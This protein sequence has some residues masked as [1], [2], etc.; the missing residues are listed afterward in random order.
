MGIQLDPGRLRCGLDLEALLLR[1]H[2]DLL[3]LAVDADLERQAIWVARLRLC[4]VDLD[5]LRRGVILPTAFDDGRPGT[6]QPLLEE[7]AQVRAETSSITLRKSA[8]EAL[9]SRYRR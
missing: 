4:E 6:V 3:D 8:V 7:P 2:V 1:A 5:L 9:L